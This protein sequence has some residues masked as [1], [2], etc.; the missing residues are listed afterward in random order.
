MKV[1]NGLLMLFLIITLVY[2]QQVPDLILQKNITEDYI[3]YLDSME[4]V[5]NDTILQSSNDESIMK[6]YIGIAL[7]Q[8][9]KANIQ[10]DSSFTA[11]DSL[12][13]RLENDLSI[14]IDITTETIYPLITAQNQDEFFDYL[15]NFFNNGD[16]ETFRDSLENLFLSVS[17]NIENIDSELYKFFN[18]VDLYFEEV[19]LSIDS[20]FNSTTDFDFVFKIMGSAYEDTVF[21]ISRDFF[22]LLIDIDCIGT[23]IDSSFND[24]FAKMDSIVDVENGDVAPA[25]VSF[26]TGLDYISLMIDTVKYML[27]HQPFAPLELNV[28]GLDSLKSFI[29]EIDTLLGGKEYPIGDESEGKTIKPL[30]IIEN[31]PGRSFEELFKDFYRAGEDLAYTFGGI[32]P[33]G[34][35]N[36]MYSMIK[37]DA[38][39][40]SEDDFEAFMARLDTLLNHWSQEP[41]ESDEHLGIGLIKLIKLLTDENIYADIENVLFYLEQGR[42]DSLLFYYDWENFNYS[43]E[44]KEIRYHID[45]YINSGE[46][47]NFVILVKDYDDDG[48]PYMIDA[49]DNFEFIVLLKPQVKLVVNTVDLI[50]NGL[51][52][53]ADA[54]VDFYNEIDKIF[55]LDLNPDELDFSEAES[56]S[57]II[58][59]LERANPDFLTLTDYGRQKFIEIGDWLESAFGE[60]S[61]FFENM[62]DLSVAVYPYQDD[63]GIDG[64]EFEFQMLMAKDI[65]NAIYIDF[66]EP[67]STITIDGERVNLS[68][69]FDNPPT[70]FLQMWKDYVYGIDST[71]GGLFPDR[72]KVGTVAEKP[73]PAE[74]KLSPIYPNPFNPVAFISFDLP[75]QSHVELT[76]VNLRGEIVVRL[77]NN[78]LNAGR[79]TYIWKPDNLPSGTYICV[80]K[81][82]NRVF[83]RKLTLL[84]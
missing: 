39:L 72:F 79:K 19:G 61:H 63:F 2:P 47:T 28:S 71:L 17:Q 59:I 13:N 18:E 82:D 4:T 46:V 20:V 81:A 58:A 16:Y 40:Y 57:D 54:A 53:I 56:D 69:W 70:S 10:A 5:F 12:G 83:T 41:I 1:V 26:R 42:I 73:V 14:A 25:I 24:G 33:N 38:V 78:R 55:I 50:C 52:Q 66:K 74:F 3:D 29:A 35:T 15:I 48:H 37:S 45:Q 68:A 36:N 32:F 80:L 31:M 30:A 51:Q 84:K 67:D 44:I 77:E 22:N 21:I 7:I 62:H 27:N 76:I 75:K 49:D 9:A 43:A 8:L 23:K 60:I 65:T 11:I 34:I 64:D 6:A